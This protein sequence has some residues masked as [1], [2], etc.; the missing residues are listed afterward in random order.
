LYL[1]KDDFHVDAGKSCS[2][3][4]PLISKDNV[5]K[6]AASCGPVKVAC[7]QMRSKNKGRKTSEDASLR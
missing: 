1:Q 5:A 2:M 4:G 6:N 7:A 3:G